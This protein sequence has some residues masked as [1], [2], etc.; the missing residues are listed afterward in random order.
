MNDQDVKQRITPTRNVH[1]TIAYHGAHYHG[2]QRQAVGIDTVQLHVERA[3][4]S[5][6]KHPLH[7]HGASRT[8]SGVHAEGQSAHILTCNNNVPVEGIRRAM[9]SRLPHDICIRSVRDVPVSFNAALNALGKTYRYRIH[10][11]PQ[12]DV[13]R[14]QQVFHYWRPLDPCAMVEAAQRVVGT[15]DFAGF[16]RSKD[17]RENTVRTISRCDVAI[18]EDEIQVTVAGTGFLYNQVRNIVG[19]LLE[20]G[21]GRWDPSYVDWIIE[22]QD[23]K[24]AGPTAPAEGLTLMCVH[25]NPTR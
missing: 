12:Y 18:V 7:V 11:H 3:A 19:T 22:T 16:A 9:N 21:R 15:F 23:R 25:Y 10:T 13:G 6:L 4:K 17:K 2:W 24:L 8:D 20:I 5:V 14:F 1:L